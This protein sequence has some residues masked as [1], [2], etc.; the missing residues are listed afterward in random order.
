[1][2]LGRKNSLMWRQQQQQQHVFTI[3]SI[4]SVVY[5]ILCLCHIR[6]FRMHPQI[7]LDTS[8]WYFALATV[9]TAYQGIPQVLTFEDLEIMQLITVITRKVHW[10]TPGLWDVRSAINHGPSYG[11][12]P[13]SITPDCISVGKVSFPRKNDPTFKYHYDIS[14]PFVKTLPCHI[15]RRKR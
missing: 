14:F 4:Y 11:W 8:C 10:P 6:S 13:G 1:M 3:F 7:V 2:S 15:T 12:C 9:T 5:T